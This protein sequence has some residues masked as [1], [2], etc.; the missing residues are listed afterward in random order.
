MRQAESTSKLSPTQQKQYLKRF[1][2]IESSFRVEGMDAI[3]DDAYRHAK[4][5]ILQGKMTPRQAL[6]YVVEHSTRLNA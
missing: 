4:A 2:T 1:A 5:Q 6:E 3:D